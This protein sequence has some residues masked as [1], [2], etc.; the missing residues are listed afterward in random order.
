MAGSFRNNA[1]GD[2]MEAA[3]A[4]IDRDFAILTALCE[5][6]ELADEE[7]LQRAIQDARDQAKDQVRRSMGLK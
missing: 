3:I 6:S 5:T 1:I 2:Y 4:E 7:Q